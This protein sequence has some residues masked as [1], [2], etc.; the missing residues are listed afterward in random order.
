M[1][2]LKLL[3][4]YL[5]ARKWHFIGGFITLGLASYFTIRVA[6]VVG[7]ASD[8]VRAGASTAADYR[9]FALTLLGFTLIAGAFR[10]VMRRWIVGASRDVE[11][12][13][14]NDLFAKL[15]SLP[16]SFYDR[17]KT[18]DLMARATNDIEQ[19]RSFVGPGFLQF[20]N[21]L[22]LFPIALYRML[23]IDVYLTSMIMLPLIVLPVVMNYFGNR[24]HKRF[25]KVQ[26]YY[27]ELSAMVQE[28]LAGVRVVKAF[29]QE[30]AQEEKFESMNKEYIRLNM[31]LIK[32]QAG[33]FP[34]LR[35]LTGVSLVLLLLIGGQ[36]VTRGNVT[37][38]ELVEFSL[39][40]TML[41][42]PLMALGWTYSLM[43]RGAASMD[44]IAEILNLPEYAPDA[45]S[46][47]MKALIRAHVPHNS[48]PGSIE[49]RNLT[50]RYSETTPEVLK[51]INFLINAGERLGIVGATGSGKSTIA[52]LLARLYP[53][54]G[55][56]LFIDGKD[57]MTLPLR[58][59][60]DRIG[61]V[62]QETFLFSDTI[63]NNIAFGNPDADEEK[64]FRVAQAAKIAE[65]IERFP[66]KYDTVLGER[67]INLSG[68]QK[69]RTAIARALLRDPGIIV[70][71]DALSAVD[72]ET[73][74][75]IL[76]SLH[77][78]L[79][80]RTAVIIAHRV[81]AVMQCEKIIV[82]DAGEVVESGNHDEL[83]ERNGLYAELFRKQLLADAID[84][85]VG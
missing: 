7:E 29:V 32:I 5:A 35:I 46:P 81:S 45:P 51:N 4:P 72:T 14:R 67:G 47:D 48:K 41:F 69:Q 79:A 73:E 83:L 17:Q 8:A 55:N 58:E 10:F 24:V 36:E 39:I 18:G 76:E 75:L 16:P 34:V 31:H 85:E 3:K 53:I 61:I 20:F 68:G 54:E 28:N 64:I 9:N 74:A 33:F 22:F 21:S 50:F 60:R 59:L 57:I 27:S 38:G 84:Q 82:L 40:Q 80:G 56:S 6:R 65:E 26:D 25:R 12:S 30:K 13:F 52:A 19:I 77:R 43:Q 15:Q 78:E 63:K 66:Q 49:F 11:A 1:K 44:R 37:L 23:S 2:N 71:D 42:W 62:F 70:L